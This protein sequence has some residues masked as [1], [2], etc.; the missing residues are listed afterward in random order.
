MK[1]IGLDFGT[2]NSTISFLNPETDTIDIFKERADATGYI[3][4]VVSYN[5]DGDYTIGD[6]AKK[7]I[8]SKDYDVYENFKLL[9]G[10]NFNETIEGKS[11]TPIKVT[12]DF[13]KRLLEDYIK[14]QPISE[15]NSIVMTV[16]DIWSQE[17]NNLTARENIREKIKDIYKELGYSKT[18]FKLESEPVAAVAY[19]CRAHERNKDTNPEGKKYN[20]FITVIDFGGGTL[21][22]TLCKVTN[23]KTIE[24]L[25]RSGFGEY[26]DTN[27]CA[28]VAFDEAV[29]EKLVRDKGLVLLMLNLP[30][31]RQANKVC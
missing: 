22:V 4:S 9:L 24:P 14:S 8:A 11:K 25:M 21:D 19:F 12:S 18:K 16:P 17:K 29:I 30:F 20:G 26:N 2:T 23:G 10:K 28:G 15:V 1:I 5:S 3:P 7:K 13:I 27:G 31:F 6:S